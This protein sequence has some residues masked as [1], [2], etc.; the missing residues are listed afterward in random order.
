MLIHNFFFT[1]ERS[2]VGI[3]SL[4]GE[5]TDY[6]NASY[7]MVSQLTVLLK[8]AS[9]S[10]GISKVA[11]YLRCRDTALSWKAPFFHYS[12]FP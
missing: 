9:H 1:V 6:I 10:I 5:G 8:I 4:S 2:R 11:K 7:I 12:L 3:S